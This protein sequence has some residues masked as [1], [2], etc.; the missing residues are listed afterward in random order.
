M[1]YV[2]REQVSDQLTAAA[3]NGYIFGGGVNRART[4]VNIPANLL[5]P[6]DL[7]EE[8]KQL[9]EK[10]GFELEILG[11]E[12]MERLGMGALLAVA[13]GSEQPP[14]MI[15]LKY[16]GK[17]AWEDVIG[18]VGKGLTF[19]SGGISLKPSAN[20]HEMKSDMGGAAAVLGA[21]DII[22]QLKPAENVL[23]VIPSTENLVNGKALKP[24]DVIR[25]L[26]GKTIEVKK[27]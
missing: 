3:E 23:A 24:G 1:L 6:S 20:M 2:E 7:A 5:T 15:I 13:A 10:H 12:E 14:R 9:A 26:S 25:S 18:L 19:D 8:S 17:E 4:L 11:P 27:Y 16:Q 21:M 22:G